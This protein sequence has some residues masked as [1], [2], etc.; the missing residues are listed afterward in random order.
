MI[1]INDWATVKLYCFNNA[2]IN[3]ECGLHSYVNVECY[4]QSRLSVLSNNGTCT[5]YA[6]DDSFIDTPCELVRVI[7]KVMIR[8]QVF[9]G[10]EIY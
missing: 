5:V 10:E 4:D 2:S 1:K 3:M 8:G 7:R 6:Y 9:N